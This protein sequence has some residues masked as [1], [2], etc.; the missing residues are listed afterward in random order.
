LALLAG[1]ADGLARTSHPLREL[2]SHPPDAI[3]SQIQSMGALIE[4]AATRAASA[5]ESIPDRLDAI[6]F[7]ARVTPELSGQ[8][9]LDLLRPEQPVEVQSGSALALAEL[10]DDAFA[11]AVFARWS[12]Y[13]AATRGRTLAAAARST[14]MTVALADALERGALSPVELDASVR[15]SLL[16]TPNDSLKQRLQKLLAI[17]V[18]P[19]RVEVVARFQ[20]ALTMEGDRR[21]GAAIFAK[22][23]LLCH[24]VEGHGRHVGPDLSGIASRP[25]EAL[26]VDILDPSRQVSPDFINYTLVTAD[27]KFVTGFIVTETA[28]SVTLRRAG[29][30]DETV[31]RS[32]IRTLR[33]EGK[34]LMPEGL[35]QGLATQDMADL[36]SFLQKPEG[37]LLPEVK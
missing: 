7:L 34:S 12:H 20:P 11:K 8:A 2:I 17:V 28:A 37:R 18:S 13:A 27:G 33:A 5:R 4:M 1:L 6:R 25:K 31:L 19:D 16:K 21:R 24:T 35:E 23:C 30:A 3:K 15:Q 9:L 29:E 10:D 14:A 22:T 32:Q 36:L 26:L